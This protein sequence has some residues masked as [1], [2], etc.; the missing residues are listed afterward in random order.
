MGASST[1]VVG[2]KLFSNAKAYIK[3]LN[4][5]PGWRFAC[6]DLLNSLFLKLKP[7]DNAKTL[8]L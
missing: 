4:A 3:G 2:E 5:E 1:S 6:D 7:P 8:P